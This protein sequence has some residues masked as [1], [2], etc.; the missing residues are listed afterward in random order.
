MRLAR[1]AAAVVV[2]TL[3][4]LP[5]A[6]QNTVSRSFPTQHFEPA[7]GIKDTFFSVESAQTGDH[8]SFSLDLMF[9][10]QHRPLVLFVQKST[11]GSTT[12][13]E[14]GKA[15]AIDVV[16]NQLTMD[17]GGAFAVRF[18]W[19]RGQI[20]LSL[21]VNLLLRGTEVDDLGNRTGNT[22]SATGVGDLRMQLKVMLLHDWKGL[23]LAVSP[24]LT[25]PTGKRDNFG[26][27]PNLSVRPRLALDYRIGNFIAALDLGWMIRESVMMFSS[28]V[29]DQLMYGVGAGYRV[30]PRVLL[31][32]E[33]YGRAGFK[34]RSGCTRDP[35]SG[36]TTCTDTS[37]KDLDAFPLEADLGARV[38][39]GS[40]FELAAG[41][42]FGIIKA[43]GSP[44]AR[45]LLGLRWAPDFTDTDRDGIADA[46]D[47]CP[48]QK[49]DKDGFR[50]SDGCPDPDNDEDLIPD[51]RDRCP[52]EPED[53]D[54]FEDD[55]GCPDP[56]NDKDGIPDLKDSCP[57]QPE[58]KNGLKD[59]DGC[60]DIP[61]QDG[62]GIEDSKDQ[63]PKE[64]ED[65]D[66]F[67]DADGC[68]DPDNDN[69]GVPDNLDDC[70]NKPEDMDG[71][72]DNDGCPDP[73]NDGDGVPDAQDKCPN[74]PETING[75]K[76]EDG[77][78]DKG[79]GHVVVKDNRI[80]IMK[81]IFFA[82]DK[83]VIR[84]VSFA[85][86][87]EVALTLRANPQ[88][89]GVRIEGHT[90]SQGAADHNRKLSQSRAEAVRIFLI[91]EGIE[92][93]RLFA[94][95]YGS[96]KPVADNRTGKGREANRRVEFVI[97]ESAPGAGPAG[98]GQPPEKK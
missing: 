62:D 57:F 33:L 41:A 9:N 75:Y 91:K 98:A 74:E 40:G 13:F 77:C 26:G 88:I 25:F 84:S 55:D 50:D 21:P 82:T 18:G 83:A 35:I 85:I 23:S 72:K 2:S 81:K 61:D 3:V 7:I 51:D 80:Q 6:A 16:K 47:K 67:K 53:K 14:L 52:N 30:H 64:P 10:Y 39:L 46:D 49:E 93:A 97:L 11:P 79:T 60:P 28:E 63:C 4:S 54:T 36:T 73:D 86:L 5:A 17:V 43:I 66:G 90:D 12:P 32:G 87:K 70:P 24:I 42:G 19:F 29:D 15:D 68:P 1:L 69:D 22:L 92:G 56:D 38:K 96:D 65:K 44:Q 45:A 95:G 8:L 20:G 94:Q 37:G 78:P 71:F 89:K 58:N 59:D 76:D 48:T 27:D 34:T 31:M